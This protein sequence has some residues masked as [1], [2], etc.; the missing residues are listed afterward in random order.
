[1][2]VETVCSKLS[3]IIANEDVDGKQGG[4][5]DACLRFTK[6]HF[7]ELARDKRT[8]ELSSEALVNLVSANDLRCVLVCVLLFCVFL[9]SLVFL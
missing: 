4:G 1:M 7:S 8:R 9:Y 5:K 6:D 3:D 2:N